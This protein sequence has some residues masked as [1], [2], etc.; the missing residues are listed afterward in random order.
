M[1]PKTTLLAVRDVTCAVTVV[2]YK[3]AT[4]NIAWNKA[5]YW[6]EL[7]DAISQFTK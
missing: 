3:L 1:N 7:M 4:Y 5:S 6:Y 2:R